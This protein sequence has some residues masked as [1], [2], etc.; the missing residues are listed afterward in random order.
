[1]F[2]YSKLSQDFPGDTVDRSL[3]ANARDT[4]MIPGL[5]GFHMP[6]GASKPMHHN[7]WATTEALA[8]RAC[9]SQQENLLQ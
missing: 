1:M 3:P 9:A 5:G 2:H 8:S 7:Y 6:Q 4:G